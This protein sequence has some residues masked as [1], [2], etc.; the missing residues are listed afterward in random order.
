MIEK[1]NPRKLIIKVS[2]LE[3]AGPRSLINGL[4]AIKLSE[5]RN[6]KIAELQIKNLI[7]NSFE[8]NDPPSTV[9]IS[10]PWA[11]STSG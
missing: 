3:I 10:G 1:L 6:K 11:L 4:Y 2:T 8:S 5:K 9:E 7:F